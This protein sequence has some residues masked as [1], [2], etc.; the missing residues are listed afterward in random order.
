MF[1]RRLY[2]LLI[3]LLMPIGGFANVINVPGDFATIQ[4]AIDDVV[5]MDGNTI[6]VS[7]GLYGPISFRGSP[8][9]I[10]QSIDPFDAATVAATIISDNNQGATPVIF[11]GTETHQTI[12]EGFTIE[13]LG[14]PVNI[15]GVAGNGTNAQLR[16]CVIQNNVNNQ[17]GGGINNF[18]GPIIACK[19]VNNQTFL[20]GG[21]LAG[22]DGP[23]IDCLI[24]GNQT[25]GPSGGGL[26]FCNGLITNCT[27][28]HN[29]ATDQGGGLYQSNAL[30]SSS[31]I[32]ENIAPLDPQIQNP[33]P[34]NVINSCIM[35]WPFP[36]MGNIS[37]DPQFVDPDGL[38]NAFFTF[39][40]NNY[41]LRTRSPCIDA[42]TNT[43]PGGLA[44]PGRDLNGRAR[45]VNI[46]D[47][48]DVREPGIL[49]PPIVDMGCLE[50]QNGFSLGVFD[51]E[52]PADFDVRVSGPPS[53]VFLLTQAQNPSIPDEAGAVLAMKA[54]N[55]INADISFYPTKKT[56]ITVE[57][58][59]Y[60]FSTP[61]DSLLVV[62]IANNFP[63]GQTSQELARIHP[64]GPARPGSA[65]S[66]HMG[67]FKGI[68]DVHEDLTEGSILRFTLIPDDGTGGGGNFN[69][70][71]G[72]TAPSQIWLDDVELSFECNS[73]CG[74]LNGDALL[75]WQDVLTHVTVYGASNPPAEQACADPLRNGYINGDD[76]ALWD[77][78]DELGV[79]FS[80][81]G[82]LQALAMNFIQGDFEAQN[83]FMTVSP[84]TILGLPDDRSLQN[85]FFNYD[86]TPTGTLSASS[87]GRTCDNSCDCSGSSCFEGSGTCHHANGRLVADGEGTVYQLDAIC[88]LINQQ[89]GDRI[90]ASFTKSHPA[91]PNTDV[92]IGKVSG[93]ETTIS[94]ID[95][96]FSPD[97]P[98]TV[99]VIPVRVI[100]PSGPAY[101]AAAK[102]NLLPNGDYN[103]ARIYGKNPST[104]T[105]QKIAQS[106]PNDFIIYEPHT[107]DMLE[108]EINSTSDTLFMLCGQEVGENDFV[109]SYNEAVGN[110][111]EQLFAISGGSKIGTWSVDGP[112]SLLFSHFDDSLWITSSMITTTDP[113]VQLYHYDVSINAGIV[114]LSNQQR[115]TLGFPD[116]NLSI[117]TDVPGV[118]AGSGVTATATSLTASPGDGTVYVAGF[119]SPAL[120]NNP[121]IDSTYAELFEGVGELFMTPVLSRVDSAGVVQDVSAISNDMILAN[122]LRMPLSVV[123]QG[124]DFGDV[125]GDITRDCQVNIKDLVKLSG[126]WLDDVPPA[127]PELLLAGAV[128]VNLFDFQ[129][130]AENWLT[131]IY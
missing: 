8:N 73:V 26:A 125:P 42:G 25:N 54:A 30:I 28:A 14:S 99:Y 103:L 67:R 95:A 38:D 127:P 77:I 44:Q 69:G 75:D 88:G 43:P 86:M 111:S 123:W 35:N 74:D 37:Q 129:V 76:V 11:E 97:D 120:A 58:N 80:G 20:F 46:P 3:L 85:I 68:F 4:E 113:N 91:D 81:G 24:A 116:P 2:F 112:Q 108:I 51:A 117:C 93:D 106:D 6:L 94:M 5:T 17:S 41:S 131:N 53:Q 31:I 39:D 70:F 121:F 65:T 87:G 115:T 124:C 45:R 96:V 82:S 56:T 126:Y 107:Q 59:Y 71:Q 61:P 109:M 79:C 1:K 32:W 92:K 89:T 15:G 33:Q 19:I 9:L 10:V 122:P 36:G 21:G 118:C 63:G 114:S 49:G 66:K 23:I 110:S 27:V 55:P 102:L 50:H 78:V 40:D 98:N 60:F 16:R 47:S 34:S 64:P 72:A 119:I 130:I 48:P 12:L 101:N 84:L 90:V 83:S 52:D 22:C 100:P 57:F 13:T 104:E 105:N 29:Q 7:P 62:G 18:D 128:T